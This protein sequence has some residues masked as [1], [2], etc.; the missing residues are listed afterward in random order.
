MW[1]AVV[2]PA[3]LLVSRWR[4]VKLKMYFPL[5]SLSAVSCGGYRNHETPQKSRESQ[6]L[7]CREKPEQSLIRDT[8][9][10]H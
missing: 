3:Y 5:L 2:H 10:S 9:D 7:W 4:A 6:T 8:Q 1:G